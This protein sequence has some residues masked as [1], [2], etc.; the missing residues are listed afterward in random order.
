MKIKRLQEIEDYIGLCGTCSYEE[1]CSHFDISLSTIRRDI[2]ELEQ[3]GKIMK[4]HGGVMIKKEVLEEEA[5][6]K[7]QL[8]YGSNKDRIAEIASKIVEDNDIILLGS[9][10]TVA[11]MVH[12]LAGKKNIT[13]ITNNLV[14]IEEA[15]KYGFSVIIV[16]GNLDRNTL[17]FV[18]TQTI[19]QLNELNANKSFIS[20]NGITLNHGL[21][22][23][24]DLE[25]DIKKS[26]IKISSDVIALVD[27]TKFDKMSL[28]TFA[29]INE[30]NTLITDA[31]PSSEYI[32]L[33]D[34]NNTRLEI[35]NR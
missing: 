28:Y 12:H 8:Q 25:A 23:V 2:G 11:H 14:V 33:F 6:V 3:Y 22:N 15:M 29:G 4:I 31:E 17:S 35:A 32:E 30:I 16:G 18:G 26:I 21:S 5:E 1:L 24:A 9:G 27:H 7:I 13:V 10:S 19:K 20:C 34:K